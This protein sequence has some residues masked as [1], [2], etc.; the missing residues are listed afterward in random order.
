M[1]EDVLPAVKDSSALLAVQLVDEVSGEVLVGVLVPETQTARKVFICL[2]C[3]PESFTWGQINAE[4][5]LR[6]R[7]FFRPS[8]DTTAFHHLRKSMQ[9]NV[10]HLIMI[11]VLN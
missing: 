8:I 10:L 7:C 3:P 2:Y 6:Q 4:T 1:A 5:S 9:E 11:Y